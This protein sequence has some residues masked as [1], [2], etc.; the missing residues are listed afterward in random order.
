MRDADHLR[1]ISRAD[2]ASR[3]ADIMAELNAIHP[4][5]EGNGRT[6]RLFV[7]ELAREAGHVL[8]F[9]VVSRE[10]MIAASVAANED[11]DPAMMRR[12]FV[13][14]SDPSRVAALRQAI[15]F[16]ET[17]SFPWNDRYIATTEPGHEVELTLAGV[18][19]AH[20][21]GRTSAQIL[22]GK[23]VDLPKPRPQRHETFTIVPS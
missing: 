20:F 18:A 9:T 13:E 17:Q 16:L 8:D 6:Q 2:F 23:T 19:G 12:L 22:I 15:D 3:A 14:I 4:F 10:R 11:G 1:G 7:S 21:M 5:R